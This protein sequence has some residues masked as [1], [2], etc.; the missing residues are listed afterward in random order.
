MKLKDTTIN[1]GEVVEAAYH[2]GFSEGFDAAIE[3]LTKKKQ[4]TTEERSDD[5]EI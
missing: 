5:K 3:L 2:K 4:E 1:T